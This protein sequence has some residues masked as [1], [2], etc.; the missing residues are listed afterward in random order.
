MFPK[1]LTLIITCVICNYIY[2]EENIT[3]KSESIQVKH[4]N[5]KTKE[6]NEIKNDKWEKENH[7]I[8][9][10]KTV[11]KVTFKFVRGV[12]NVITGWGEIPRQLIISTMN[13]EVYM[14]L[15]LGLSRGIALTIART[16]VGAMDTIFFF[17]SPDGSYSSLINPSF[18]WEKEEKNPRKYYP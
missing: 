7:H 8:P 10:E 12:T 11:D 18:V 3:Q 2:A 6:E 17:Y 9:L 13:D 5:L 4:E 14:I 16:V 1:A 15:P